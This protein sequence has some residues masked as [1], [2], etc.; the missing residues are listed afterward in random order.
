M[1]GI[2]ISR[3]NFHLYIR[4]RVLEH[5]RLTVWSDFQ[6]FLSGTAFWHAETFARAEKISKSK[7]KNMSFG[8]KTPV[9][10]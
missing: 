3:A 10:I 6:T 1:I 7:K 4:I 9:L 8:G 2:W 5:I